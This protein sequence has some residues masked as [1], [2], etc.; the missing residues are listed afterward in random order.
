VIG[1]GHSSLAQGFMAGSIS[2]GCNL[3]SRI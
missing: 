3:F 2:H 1:Q